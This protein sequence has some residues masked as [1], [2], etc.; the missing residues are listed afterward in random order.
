MVELVRSL[1][2]IKGTNIKLE[3]EKVLFICKY[4]FLGLKYPQKIRLLRNLVQ[5]NDTI[6]STLHYLTYKVTKMHLNFSLK[7]NILLHLI[8]MFFNEAKK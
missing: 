5:N 1:I 2:F 7:T 6:S 8:F 3:L 4:L